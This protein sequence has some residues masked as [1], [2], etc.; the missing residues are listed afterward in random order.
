MIILHVR[1]TFEDAS[2]SKKAR[3]LNMAQLYMQMLRRVPNIS[4]YGSIRL[5][6]MSEYG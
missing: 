1:Q 2:G 4:E 5:S 3:V 6:K